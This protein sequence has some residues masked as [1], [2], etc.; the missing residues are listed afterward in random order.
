MK[1]QHIELLQNFFE[2]HSDSRSQ[3]KFATPFAVSDFNCTFAMLYQF[4]HHG[5]Y[6]TNK[7]KE[8]DNKGA[9]EFKKLISFLICSA[10][11][12][13]QQRA[14]LF[15]HY[16]NLFNMLYQKEKSTTGA[17]IGS[18]VPET[19]RLQVSVSQQMEKGGLPC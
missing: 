13:V 17:S 10:N 3:L 2:K 14:P 9:R 19:N 18:Y 16:Q 7:R 12:L 8:P 6:S 11:G 4:N 5:A 1:N 15:I